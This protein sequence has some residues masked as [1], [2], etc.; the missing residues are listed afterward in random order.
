M[1]TEKRPPL[2]ERKY[3]RTK[4]SL[5]NAAVQAMEETALE[6]ISVKALC[7]EADVSE[8]T[9]FNY[10]TKK[11]DLLDYFIQLWNLELTWHHQHSDAKGLALLEHSFRQI[12]RQ[13]QKHPGVMAEIISHQTRQR[14]RPVLP[15]IDR[16]ERLQA[17][18]KL[19]G[20]ETQAIEGL[21]QMW[22]NA[23]QQAIDRGELPSNTHL[24]TTL[25]GLATI[26]YGT[27]LALGQKKLTT[28][29]SVYRQQ[30]NL[31]LAGIRTASQH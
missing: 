22:V 3:A 24:A 9:F 6:N 21:D 2:R 8:A 4:L 14:E 16:A 20:I 29:A 15:K 30:V 5:L 17:F 28:V 18:P 1:P 13:Y 12:A 27:P 31:F 7:E 25:T 23:L 19:A 26:F 11:T 10:F